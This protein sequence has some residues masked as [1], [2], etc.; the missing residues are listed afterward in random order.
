MVAGDG[1]LLAVEGG[2]V[3]P[4]AGIV[5]YANTRVHKQVTLNELNI[6]GH[7]WAHVHWVDTTA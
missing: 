1:Y 4:L 3:Y 6:A 7:V 5:A 2:T